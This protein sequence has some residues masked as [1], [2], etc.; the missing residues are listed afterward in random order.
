MTRWLL[1]MC[2]ISTNAVAQLA[3]SD[4]LRLSGFG[5]F[6]AAKSDS[7]TPVIDKRDLTDTWCFDCDSTLGLQ[8][9]WRISDHF[10][11]AIQILKRP[12]DHF[13]SP[14]LERA[15]IEYSNQTI[16]IKAGRLRTPLFIISEYYYVSNA[17]PWL[18]LPN[19]VY[20]SF[21]GLTHYEG[22][23]V[24]WSYESV[25][26]GQFVLSPFYAITNEE[27]IEQYGQ[28]FDIKLNNTLGIAANWLYEDHQ[29]HAAFVHIDAKQ[30]F[31]Q[32]LI[33][34]L[35]LDVFSLGASYTLGRWHLQSEWLLTND[36]HAN[37]YASIDYTW[38]RFT[39]YFTY[40]Q[41]RRNIDTQSYL[42]GT[43]YTLS[44]NVNLYAEWQHISGQ[45]A[46]LSGQFTL[47]Q[48]PLK[49]FDTDVNVISLGL[50]FTF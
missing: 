44:P 23:V 10:R 48:N 33:Q 34:E 11:S 47:P 26:Q 14:E 24:D 45:D 28:T 41:S 30:Y 25:E 1:V 13:S 36:L 46:M 50:S 6:S 8:L 5:T 42:L 9:D 27:E 35:N 29:L 3:L 22:L 17:Y 15:F 37:W 38:Q 12:Q 31:N 40:G 18:R 16:T 43:S 39:P 20:T 21:R 2:F 49:P 19:E 4:D 7:V 32:F